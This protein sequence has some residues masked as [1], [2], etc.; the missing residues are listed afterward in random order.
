MEAYLTGSF[1]IEVPQEHLPCVI[2]RRLRG[3]NAHGDRGYERSGDRRHGE[4]H[5]DR[6]RGGDG[7]GTVRWKA[8]RL[9]FRERE[10]VGRR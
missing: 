7:Y 3:R 8:G 5:G 1:F 9:C 4:N 2:I 10:R 6:R